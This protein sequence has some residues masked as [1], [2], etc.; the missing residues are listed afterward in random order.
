[1]RTGAVVALSIPLVLAVTFLL[2]YTFGIDLQRISLGALVIALG[3]LVDDA[4]IAVEMMVV[5]MEQGWDRFRAATFAY[6]STAFPML[7][8]T[9]IS[10]IGF[11][12]VGL[13]RSGAGEYTSSIF[14]VVSIALLVSWLVAVVFTP[15]LGHLL[16]DADQLHRKALAHGEDRYETAF[17]RRCGG[18]SSGALR[19]RWWVIAATVLAF[20]AAL[21]GL[22]SA[23]RNSSS[24]RRVAPSCWS[25]CGCR[26]APR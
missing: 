5:K 9:L 23:C 6:T 26:T 17:Y 13:A 24:R 14:F 3:L 4:I 8:G 16:L 7:T 15:F 10:A 12:P 1:M 20:A 11:M 25:T 19:Q 21:A 2:M 18:S 22:R